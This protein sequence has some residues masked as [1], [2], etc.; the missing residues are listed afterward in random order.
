MFHR[1]DT[2]RLEKWIQEKA[3]EGRW[4][5]GPQK[6]KLPDPEGACGDVSAEK[7]FAKSF[8]SGKGFAQTA[9]VSIMDHPIHDQTIYLRKVSRHYCLKHDR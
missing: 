7:N 9:N 6:V 8:V 1:N 2:E 3:K 5:H 4:W